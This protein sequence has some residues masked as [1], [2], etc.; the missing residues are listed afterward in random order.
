VSHRFQGTVLAP[1]A[2]RPG[3]APNAFLPFGFLNERLTGFACATRE[4]LKD[5]IFAIFG[6]MSKDTLGAVFALWIKR[7]EWVIR[8]RA[9]YYREWNND[10]NN[11]SAITHRKTRTKQNTNE[12]QTETEIKPTQKQKH[13]QRKTTKTKRQE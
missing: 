8:H 13:K 5:A 6:E 9:D 1:P 12:N 3:L 10:Q 7:L 4:Q 2:S 11:S